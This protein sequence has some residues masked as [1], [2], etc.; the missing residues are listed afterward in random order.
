MRLTRRRFLAISAGALAVPSGAAA[1]A[2]EARWRG[3][4]LGAPAS[5]VLAGVSREEA[6]PVF[7]ALEA[8]LDRLENVFSLYRT[9]SALSRLNRD[10]HLPAPPPEMLEVLSL[11]DT[12]HGGS[13][14]AFDPTVQ[15]LWKALAAGND[16]ARARK[17]VGWSGVRFG[18]DEIRFAR[19]GMALT[20]NGIAQGYV[21]DCVAALLRAH[22]F[23]DVLVD[24]GEIAASGWKP[25]GTPW[26]AGISDVDARI[27]RRVSLSDRALATSAV[28]GT[29]LPNG[30]GHIVR[31]DGGVPKHRLVSVSAPK[32]VLA[33]GLSTAICLLDRNSSQRL[34]DRF[35]GALIELTT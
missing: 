21:T 11:A 10:G 5:M 29:V 31:P 20:L 8:E 18:T 33:D 6:Q 23:G 15:P 32:A 2:A 28:N 27:L 9:T 4:A 26:Q 14:G 3:V 7:A 24:I 16:T 34:V 17:A 1:R 22:G 12:L 25:D 30:R 13:G 19:E 35:P